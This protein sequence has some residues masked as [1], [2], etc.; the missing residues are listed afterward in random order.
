MTPK[1]ASSVWEHPCLAAAVD[2]VVDRVSEGLLDTVE[3]AALVSGE[4]VYS[5]ERAV[6]DLDPRCRTSG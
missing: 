2:V 1:L 3:R 6:D 4:A 5:V